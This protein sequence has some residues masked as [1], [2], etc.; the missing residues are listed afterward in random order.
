MK[1]LQRLLPLFTLVALIS[2]TLSA[3]YIGVGITGDIPLGKLDE[4]DQAMDFAK[5][6]Q[7]IS[8]LKRLGIDSN[9][10]EAAVTK[11]STKDVTI[12]PWHSIGASRE[13]YGIVWLSDGPQGVGSLHLLAS[14]DKQVWHVIDTAY[15]STFSHTLTYEMLTLTSGEEILLVH[16]I[17][18]G[19]GSNMLEDKAEVFRI[20][21]GKLQSVLST[22]DYTL[23]PEEHLAINMLEKTSTFL[24][25][26]G[27]ALEETRI[28]SKEGAREGM[29]TPV[30]VDRR[31]WNWSPRQHSFSATPFHPVGKTVGRR[32]NEEEVSP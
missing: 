31:L 3:Q 2:S 12:Q 10:A 11:R 22:N 5:P 20:R 30:R 25:F 13:L 32:A 28:T 23:E 27:D 26:P 15:L 1:L 18:V 16:H 29:D 17:N 24:L 8:L 19:H 7:K 9:T 6:E 14:S 21:Q 4:M